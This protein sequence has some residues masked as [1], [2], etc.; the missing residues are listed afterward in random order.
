MVEA[1]FR[2]AAL[3]MT[4]MLAA[5]VANAQEVTSR[6]S[7]YTV[8]WS[9]STFANAGALYA[10]SYALSESLPFTN[11][12]YTI[13]IPSNA[14]NFQYLQSP[15]VTISSPPPSP[16]YPATTIAIYSSDGTAGS[17]GWQFNIAAGSGQPLSFGDLGGL[18]TL[19]FDVGGSESAEFPYDPP[20][21][22]YVFVYLPGD[23]TTEGTST[24]DHIFNSVA[25]NFSPPTFTYSDGWTTVESVKSKFTSGAPDLNFTLVGSAVPESST[26]AMMLLGFAGLGFAASR[27]AHT[28]S[29]AIT[30]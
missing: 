10:V 8:T 1:G 28:K 6:T 24:G 15:G 27:M 20:I 22:Y 14:Q 7:A 17:W 4:G 13:G 21:D 26:W 3:A 9:D 16:P 18:P 29:V 11:S 19:N 30:A 2:L 23:W 25:S 5:G 12:M